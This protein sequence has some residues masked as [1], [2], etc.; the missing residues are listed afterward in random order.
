[1]A[2]V[3]AIREV[4]AEVVLIPR[5][6]TA[7]VGGGLKARTQFATVVCSMLTDG[8]LR[9]ESYISFE[10][11]GVA[12]GF[13]EVL[14]DAGQ[15]LIG[16]EHA[17]RRDARRVVARE[18]HDL[19]PR[20]GMVQLLLSLVDIA[21][22]DLFGKLSNLPVW[23]LIGGSGT[24]VRCYA[25]HGLFSGETEDQLEGSARRLVNEGFVGVKLRIGRRPLREDIARAKRVRAAVG[26]DVS[27]MVDGLW[28]MRSG[29]AIRFGRAVEELE[30]SWLED[31][32]AEGNLAELKR[33]RNNVTIPV[34]SAE[35][36]SSVDEFRRLIDADV[37]DIAIIDVYHIGGVSPWLECAALAADR[38]VAVAGHA[39]PAY[40]AHLVSAVENGEVIEYFPWWDEL[41]GG[42]MKPSNGAFS[43]PDAPGWGM[44]LDPI[45][46]DTY[47]AELTR[48]VS[49]SISGT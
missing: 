40:S 32:T 4:T 16:T 3:D 1:M 47:R 26:R 46:I 27:I 9:G 31:P 39:A 28:S 11:I 13:A 30:I 34:A 15:A 10:S 24:D 6:R 2:S 5:P 35:R 14:S 45:A 44:P 20:S 21:L 18:L 36:V 48:K 23:R 7:A 49:T 12:H 33:V 19:L 37:V 8:G 42:A 38:G 25:S 29:D 41:Q 22:W 17:S 43:M